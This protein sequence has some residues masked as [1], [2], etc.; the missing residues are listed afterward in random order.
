MEEV[1][2]LED[3]DDEYY[4]TQRL[5]EYLLPI[6]KLLNRL[7]K[8]LLRISKLDEIEW[9]E[10]VNRYDRPDFQLLKNNYWRYVDSKDDYNV[11][12]YETIKYPPG[13]KPHDVIN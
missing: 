1:N 3:N 2:E 4:T 13:V 9:R 11:M 12:V 6:K 7:L 5:I 10:L 8:R